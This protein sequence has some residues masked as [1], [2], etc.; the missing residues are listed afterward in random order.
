[1]QFKTFAAQPRSGQFRAQQPGHQR[2]AP[3]AAAEDVEKGRFQRR[4][5]VRGI[6]AGKQRGSTCKSSRVSWR[7]MRALSPT[8]S[9]SSVRP[10]SKDVVWV[11]GGVESDEGC[12][13]S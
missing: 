10:C 12:M 9:I 11:T 13:R 3:Q 6:H 4:S 5:V 7:T 2:A 8:A 1:M